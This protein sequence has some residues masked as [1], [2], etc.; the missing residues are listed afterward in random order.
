ML[1]NNIYKDRPV[2][3]TGHTGFKGGWLAAWLEKLGS[4]VCGYACDVPTVPNHFSLLNLSI[5]DI[6]G[7]VSDFGTLKDSIQRFSPEIVFHLTAQSLV[8]LSFQKPLETFA[9]N[10]LGTAHILEACRQTPSV[11]AVIIITSDKCY[12]QRE[13]KHGYRETDPLGGGDPYSASKACA[14]IVTA[15]YRKSFSDNRLLIASCRSGNALGGGDW[16]E[17]RLIPDLVRSAIGEK[18]A[19]LRMPHAIRPWQHVLNP[20]AGYLL[21]GQRLL[22]DRAEF[23]ESWNFGPDQSD[24][25]TVNEVVQHAQRN[26]DKIRYESIPD[27]ESREVPLL[28]LNVQKARRKLGWKPGWNLREGIEQ[29]ISWYRRFCEHGEVLT[30][31]QIAEFEVR[32]ESMIR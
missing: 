5:K 2:F 31:G 10:I 8:P 21:L 18:I 13:R 25:W 26:W 16:A 28:T 11:R 4:R 24:H 27:A 22:E 30:L 1:F 23:A 6:R 12:A 19:V 32:F 14:E 15:S 9:V 7:D 3:I 29:T 20:L 17:N